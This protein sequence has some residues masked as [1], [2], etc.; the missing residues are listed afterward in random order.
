MKFLDFT[1]LLDTEPATLAILSTFQ[2]DADFFERRLLQCPSLRNARRILI[3]MDSCQWYK[4]LRQDVPARLLN[5]RYLVVP[6]RPPIGVFHPKLSLLVSEE[7]GQ[8]LCGSNNLTRSGCSSNLELLNSVSIMSEVKND[9]ALRLAQESLAFFKRACDYAELETGRIARQWLEELPTY[10]TWL[11]EKLP[12]TERRMVQLIHT[13]D[14]S[15]WDRLTTLLDGVTP[16]RFLIIS[17]YFD[18][19]AELI[20]RTRQRWPKALIEIVVQQDTTNLPVAALKKLRPS[21]ALSEFRN[22]SRRLHAKLLAWES[23]KG[24]GCIVGSA[25]FTTA[26]YDARNIE[27]CFLISNAEEYVSGL[28]DGQFTKRNL[29][30]DDFNPGMEQEPIEENDEETTLRVISAILNESGDIKVNYKH[31]L[32][33]KPSSLRLALRTPGEKRPR[34]FCILPNKESGSA[35]VSIPEAAQRDVH[36]TILATIVAQIG[37]KR[38]ESPPIWVIQEGRLTYEPSGGGSSSSGKKV[39]ETGEGLAEIL[40]E[41]GKQRGSLAIIEYLRNLDIRFHDGGGGINNGRKFHLKIRDPFQS[42]NA[43]SWLL[44]SITIK[45]N[46]AEAIYDF[47]DRHDAKRLRKHT[48]RGNI[49][50]MENFLDIFTTLV[51]LLYIYY[52]RNT[53]S[54]NKL[55]HR[56][57]RFIELAT[58]GISLLDDWCEGYLNSISQNLGGS[59]YLQEVIDDLNYLGHVYA[60]LVIAQRVRFLPD[61]KCQ[62]GPSPKRPQ[63]CLSNNKNQLVETIKRLNLNM[64]SKTDVVK[65]LEY[66]NMF[67]A[68]ELVE[69]QSEAG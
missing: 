5:S 49:N 41:L 60:A 23:S 1:S 62:W 63:E 67:N 61:E 54:R 42:D 3:F 58:G 2:L 31:Q 50:G 47:V 65:A 56:L 57:C 46:L 15:L 18:Y 38:E 19:E 69:L 44:E 55:I 6:V 11:A 13:Y 4:L 30:V 64:P 37:D 12:V 22:T 52:V 8:V 10:I 45:D 43:P 26:A 7:G 21:I 29:A 16:K 27:T 51:R 17:P 53:V 36:G 14:G 59:K 28:F 48:R 35:T 40:E 9:E 24:T 33:T 32:S 25:N 68:L 34:A 66:Y 20:K 39:E